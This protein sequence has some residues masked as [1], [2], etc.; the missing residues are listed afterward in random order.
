MRLYLD[1]NVYVSKYKDEFYGGGLPAY[2]RYSVERLLE[3]ALACEFF[4]VSSDLVLKEIT[5]KFG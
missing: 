1:T 2:A 4:V 5:D 3:R